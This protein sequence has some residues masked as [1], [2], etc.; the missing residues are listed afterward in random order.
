MEKTSESTN[1][2]NGRLRAEVDR[3]NTELKE[4]RKRLSMNG[5]GGG[6]SPP[7]AA[8]YSSQARSFYNN[9][10]DFQF[11][12]P[13]FGDLPTFMS[14]GSLS[15]PDSPTNTGQR[16]SPPNALNGMRANSY[17]S[18]GVNSPPSLNGTYNFESSNDA[19][20]YPSPTN[21]SDTIEE[22]NGLFSPSILETA[23][24]NNSSDYLNFATAAAISHPEKQDSIH[25]RSSIS[26]T[27]S[28]PSASSVSNH[29]LD[30]SCGTTPEPSADSPDNRKGSEPTLNTI[31]EEA[32]DPRKIQG[33]VK[34]WIRYF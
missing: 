34:L 19:G 12:F 18:V 32:V 31:K 2:E 23:R 1:H 11:A 13:K 29:G 17:G 16:V 14:S 24:R 25:S 22:L 7:S 5:T 21:S 15:K 27:T 20:I 30:S 28:S 10:N 26:M 4:Y 8:G 33:K 6:R 3:L 9:R